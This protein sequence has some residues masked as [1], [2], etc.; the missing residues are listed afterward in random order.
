[1][2]A[3]EAAAVERPAERAQ[4]VADEERPG[5]QVNARAVVLRLDP[6]DVVVRNDEAA[7]PV[8]DDEMPP[9]GRCRRLGVRR[10]SGS[11]RQARSRSRTRV[12]SATAANRSSENGFSR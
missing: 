5:A 6:D 2:H 9:L 7:A 3:D 1:M 12:R 8:T 11:R 4:R 10:A